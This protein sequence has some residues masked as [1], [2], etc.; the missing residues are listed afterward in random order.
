MAGEFKFGH[1]STNGAPYDSLGQRPRLGALE[2]D[3]ALKGR[4]NHCSALSGLKWLGDRKP[5]A[6]PWAVVLCPVGAEEGMHNT[7]LEGMGYVGDSRADRAKYDSPGQSRPD[8]AKYDSLG[9]SSTNGAPYDS[10]GQRPRLGALENHRALKGR[11]NRG[12]APSGLKWLGD[13]KPRA[14]PWAVISCPV[15]A[16]EGMHNN[17]REGMGYGG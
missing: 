17:N 8:R 9:H 13:R 4:Y 2:D 12:A 10:L 11:P 1:S 15:G 6:L 5:R 14:L 3:R 16:E 7:N